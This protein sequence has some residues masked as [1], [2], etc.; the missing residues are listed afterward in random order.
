MRG[1]ASVAT[2]PQPY[3]VRAAEQWLRHSCAPAGAMIRTC[4][5]S[6]PPDLLRSFLITQGADDT[7]SVVA[8][9]VVLHSLKC[10][11]ISAS[12]R[13]SHLCASIKCSELCTG[14]NTAN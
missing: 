3:R 12:A 1:R 10:E 5:E 13:Y 9:P 2:F 11:V 14:S 7:A 8:D 6:P 4:C